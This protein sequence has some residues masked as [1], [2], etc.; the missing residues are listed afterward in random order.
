MTHFLKW[1][2]KPSLHDKHLQ[3]NILLLQYCQRYSCSKAIPVS[4][5]TVSKR[6]HHPLDFQLCR[7][8]LFDSA[9]QSSLCHWNQFWYPYQMLCKL[10]KSYMWSQHW[11][12]SST[13]QVLP[14]SKFVGL[15]NNWRTNNIS[16]YTIKEE[17]SLK[18]CLGMDLPVIL[19][20]LITDDSSFSS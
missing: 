19:T 1:N 12:L 13:H 4:S 8:S 20:V 3:L 16:F 17:L 7:Q 5:S 14:K 6:W 11:H 15:N 10:I 18:K 2:C 9:H